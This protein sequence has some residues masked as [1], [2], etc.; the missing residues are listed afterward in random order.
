MSN[1]ALLVARGIAFHSTHPRF[2]HL[3]PPEAARLAQ[4]SVAAARRRIFCGSSPIDRLIVRAQERM[5][6]PGLTL[7]YVLR[8][9]YIEELVRAAIADGFG[10]LVVLGAGLD[11]L[12][13]RLPVRAIEIDHPATQ[14]LKPGVLGVD[15][16]RDPIPV[17]HEPTVYLAEGLFHYLTD[18]QIRALLAQMRTIQSRLIFTFWEPRNPPNFQNATPV[19]DWW[20]R[21]VGEPGRWSIAPEKLSSFLASEGF[22]LLHLARDDDYHRRYVSDDVPLAKGEHIAVACSE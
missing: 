14:H 6:V 22:S 21:R 12:A 19:A 1:T 13:L 9:R 11:T 10:R 2:G 17:P 4:G 16:T 18:A 3:V 7:H 5:T 15:L 20:L 8:K